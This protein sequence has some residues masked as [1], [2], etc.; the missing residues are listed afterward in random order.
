LNVKAVRYVS[1]IEENHNVNH[2]KVVWCVSII[3]TIKR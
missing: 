3:E 2:A 1:I